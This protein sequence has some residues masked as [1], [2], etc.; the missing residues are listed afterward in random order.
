MD[1]DDSEELYEELIKMKEFSKRHDV[2][3]KIFLRHLRKYYL[4]IFKT[5]NLRIVRARFCNVKSSD[6]MQAVK[7]TFEDDFAGLQEPKD[8]Y[9]F[10]FTIKL[11]L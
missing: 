11:F 1:E 4:N 8:L 3:N 6:I 7:R 2:I 5:N 9:Y 10:N